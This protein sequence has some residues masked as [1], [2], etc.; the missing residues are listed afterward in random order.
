MTTTCSICDEKTNHRNHAPINCPY[1]TYQACKQCCETYVLDQSI[2]KCMNPSCGKEWSR[3]FLV[4]KFP[5]T[6]ITGSWKKH[7]ERIL[8]EKELALL[9]ATQALIEQRRE[10]ATRCLEIAKEIAEITEN[11]RKLQRKRNRLQDETFA[12]SRGTRAVKTHKTF[13]RACP[14]EDCRGFLSTQWK[15]GLC[16]TYTCPD[17]HSIKG[18][19]NVMHECKPD[20]LA[21]AQLLDKDTKCCPKCATG[22]FKI[23]GCDQMWCTQCH[24]AFS[25]KTGE[26]QTRIHNP[27][28][29]EWQ[30]KNGSAVPREAGDIQCGRELDHRFSNNLMLKMTKY[31]GIL[32]KEKLP[33]E[34][35]SLLKEIS[36]TIRSILHLREVQLDRY[37]VDHVEDNQDLR[38]K[39][40]EKDI[41]KDEFQIRIQRENKKHD[42]KQEMYD[43]LQLLITTVTDIMYR[44]VGQLDE[45]NNVVDLSLSNIKVILRET[46]AIIDYVNQ[47]LADIAKTYNSKQKKIS[48]YDDDNMCGNVLIPHKV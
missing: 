15:C 41:T 8:F 19:K 33:E 38:L 21:T 22:I 44:I 27:H 39:Y 5:K 23:E 36:R 29:Y 1:C 31:L 12:I 43:V 10:D 2:A 28:F 26:I 18:T 14:V 32:P 9:P 4:E 42:K 46:D 30:R 16:D 37:R 20:D 25:W 47:C 7:R 24:T 34:V 45:N 13:I 35:S 3:K 48:F 6:F 40:M 11:I 17:C